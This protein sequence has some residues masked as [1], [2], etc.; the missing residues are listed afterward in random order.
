[1]LAHTRWASVGIISEAERAPAEPGGARRRG[2][3]TRRGS[4]AVRDRR[5]Q[6]RRRQLR[7]SQGA[8]GLAT[9]RRDHDRRQGHPCARVSRGSAARAE[10]DE[11][12]RSTVASF[13]G[14]VAIA[15]AGRR[16]ARTAAPGAA[17]QRPGAVRRA[18]R[19]RFVV[20]SEPYGAG[21][22]DATRYLRLDGET[23][24]EP[25]NP[26]SAGPGRGRSTPRARAP[27][28][29]STPLATTAASCR[30]STRR[31]AARRDH[32]PR[33]R[34]RRLP[35]L[36]AEGDL[37]GAGVV[38]QDAARQDRRARRAGSTFAC[39]PETLPPAVRRAR[40]AT[41]TIRRVLVIGQG[42]ARD[43]RARAS[44]A[45]CAT[46]SSAPVARGRGRDRHR[47]LGLR[48]RAPT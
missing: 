25:G 15:R 22:G 18:R 41:A 31:A 4:R 42:T 43:R 45:R 16:R 8:R 23:M 38:P 24:L 28:T 40:C 10:L 1:M 27:S 33:H 17:R 39:P 14:S 19:R 34:P 47:A 5:A 36:P 12:F 3:A 21:R 37:G 44:R 26:A 9:A 7:R 2:V 13:E 46:R 6:R 20:A 48:A 35:A 11:A 32:D 29:G 30:S